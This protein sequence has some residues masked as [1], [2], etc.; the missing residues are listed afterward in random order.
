MAS[1]WP[2]TRAEP[3][4][5]ETRDNAMK[6]A[7]HAGLEIEFIRKLKAFRKED[8]VK[9]ILEE[10]GDAPGLVHIFSAMEGCKTFSAT[11]G[12]RRPASRRCG[13]RRGSACTTTSPSSMSGFGLCSVRVP[14]WTPFRL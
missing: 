10:R 6:I 1:A 3:M 12:P 9:K 8:R 4:R 13:R 7:A 2:M 11:G 5:E 14:T